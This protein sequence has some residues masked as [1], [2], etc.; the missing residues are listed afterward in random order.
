MPD[1]F[2]TNVS[3]MTMYARQFM[4]IQENELSHDRM[5]SSIKDVHHDELQLSLP[6][7]LQSFKE[8]QH[9]VS[10]HE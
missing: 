7:C 6:R 9:Q 10:L 4:D 1:D 3:E 8:H 2:V 5:L